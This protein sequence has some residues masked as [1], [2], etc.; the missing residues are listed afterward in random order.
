MCLCVCVRPSVCVSVY[1][2]V[3]V[4]LCVC[5]SA[6]VCVCACV[7]ASVR[8]YVCV[9]ACVRPS[10]CL[11]V[12]VCVCV[13]Q[14]SD[15]APGA[16]YQ[17]RVFGANLVGLGA[18]SGPSEAFLCEAWTGEQSGEA[19]GVRVYRGPAERPSVPFTRRGFY[20]DILWTFKC[21][22]NWSSSQLGDPIKASLCSLL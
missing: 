11:C 7:R 16:S 9:C 18:P 10:V 2:R 22:T 14:V 4:R 17:F 5:V 15:L 8:L 20:L 1:V 12:C 6:S 21:L 13:L 3:C 19:P